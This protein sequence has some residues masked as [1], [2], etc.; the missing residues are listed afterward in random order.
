MAATAGRMSGGAVATG[1]ALKVKEERLI[2]S[3]ASQPDERLLKDLQSAKTVIV[4]YL[5]V[6]ALWDQDDWAALYDERAGIMEFDGGLSR[7]EAEARAVEEV[8]LLRSLV[9]S[10]DG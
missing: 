8:D 1:V 9:R 7:P 2:L 3:A 10:D 5:R 6:L 4:E